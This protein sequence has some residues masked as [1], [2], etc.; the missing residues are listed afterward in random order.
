MER[1]AS[2]SGIMRLPLPNPVYL[3]LYAVAFWATSAIAEPGA[4]P[5][6]LNPVIIFRSLDGLPE[7]AR[8]KTLRFLNTAAERE[9]FDLFLGPGPE[10]EYQL[11][12]EVDASGRTGPHKIYYAWIVY[13]RQGVVAGMESGSVS[14]SETP[15]KGGAVPKAVL[16]TIAEA[17]VAAVKKLREPLRQGR[18]VPRKQEA[19]LPQHDPDSRPESRASNPSGEAE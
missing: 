5:P 17:A 15:G 4:S 16:Q 18:N 1:H 12:G 8:A 2:A 10:S 11:W 13:D 19:R 14:A 6:R 3:L 7:K 9:G